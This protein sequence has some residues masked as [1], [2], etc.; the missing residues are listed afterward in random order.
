MPWR[1]VRTSN[2]NHAN[3]FVKIGLSRSIEFIWGWCP[4]MKNL[5]ST[6]VA[7]ST[8]AMKIFHRT[9]KTYKLAQHW[10][11]EKFCNTLY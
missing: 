9:I 5:L 10:S 3:Y 2:E 7:L 6:F 8:G 11:T 1:M 4:G